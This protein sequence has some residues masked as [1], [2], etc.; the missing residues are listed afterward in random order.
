MSAIAGVD[1]ALWDIKGKFHNVPVHQLLGGQVR[2]RIKVYAWVG[3]DR[4]ADIVHLHN[5]P[6]PTVSVQPK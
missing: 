1:Q 5:R 6:S 4:P 2:N 3:G